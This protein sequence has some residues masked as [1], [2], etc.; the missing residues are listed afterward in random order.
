MWCSRPLLAIRKHAGVRHFR[1]YR[2]EERINTYYLCVPHR[3][4]RGQ[5]REQKAD[6]LL[7]HIHFP[8]YL[9]SLTALF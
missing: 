5:C 9:A 8:N 6:I 3:G 2:Q 1:I 7:Y 4:G